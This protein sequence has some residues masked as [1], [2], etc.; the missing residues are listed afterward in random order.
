M[1]QLP[2]IVVPGWDASRT[3]AEERVGQALSRVLTASPEVAARM[4]YQLGVARAHHDTVV[5]VV[6]ACSAALKALPWELLA[7]NQNSPPLEST[8]QAVVVRL[9]GGQIWSPEPMKS[10]LRVLL[11]CPRHDPASDEVARQLEETLATLRIAPAIS[12]D[13]LKDGLPPRLPGA[14]DI[15]HVICHGRREMDHVQLVLDDGEKDAGTASHRVASR[16][17]ELDLVVLDVCE[18]AQATPTDLSNIAGRMIASGAPACIA[19]RQKSSVEAAKTFSHSLYASL[20]EGRSLSAAVANG[21]AAVCG[22]AVAHPDT[23]WNNHLLHIG[24]LETVAR[25]AIIKPRWAPSGWPTGAVD[26]ADFLEMALNIAKRSRAG[27]VGLEHLALALEESDGGGETC[28]YARFILSRCGDVTTSLRRGLTPMAERSPDWSGTP[29]LKDYGI[30]L[31]EGFDLEALWRLICSE[32]HNILHEISGN[33]SLRRA[34][35][36]TVTHET[37]SEFKYTPDCGDEA[38]GPPECLQVEGGPEDGRVIIPKPGEIIG[39]WYPESDVA[40]RLYEKTTLV[41]FKLSRYHFEWVSPGRIRLRRIA[42]LVCEGQETDLI[43]GDAV[44]QDG[45]VLILTDST[46]L[47]ALSHAPGCR[48]RP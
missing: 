14:A 18:G 16:L 7:L 25:E 10:Q 15:L 34:T 46:R 28:A 19:P 20:A 38:Y 43:P 45:D 5:L 44:L 22:L 41:D 47:R 35:P 12:I 30:N 31:S 42:R 48:R 2:A 32:R 1:G 6:D 3:Q 26:A 36:S 27:F 40:H 23:R 13:M 33:T 11:W 8:R 29:R 21:R 9:M 4:A 17:C 39:R 37:H 24:D